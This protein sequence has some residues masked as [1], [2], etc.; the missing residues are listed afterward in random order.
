MASEMINDVIGGGRYD[1]VCPMKSAWD[2]HKVGY[3]HTRRTSLLKCTRQCNISYQGALCC[4]GGRADL[5]PF[6]PLHTPLTHTSHAVLHPLFLS[7]VLIYLVIGLWYARRG[8]RRSW[9]W[10][11]MPATRLPS[12]ASRVSSSRPATGSRGR[13]PEPLQPG[14]GRQDRIERRGTRRR[15][16]G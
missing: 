5:R 3:R 14:Q 9:W 7:S 8:R 11:R 4:L 13:T 10:C 6:F 2:V 12:W 16:P 15:D 1:V